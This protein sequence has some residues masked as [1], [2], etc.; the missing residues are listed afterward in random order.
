MKKEGD[1]FTTLYNND[2]IV[3]VVMLWLM[4]LLT[5]IGVGALISSSNDYLTTNSHRQGKAAFFAADSGLA[6]GTK[7]LD[8]L[9]A[10][11][12]VPTSAQLAALAAPS[13]SGFTFDAFSV[14]AAGSASLQTITT[15]PY[16]GLRASST[17]YTITSQ[18]SRT[19]ADSGTVR[20]V[21]SLQDQVIPLFQFGVFYNT[22]LEI[23][24]GA[25]MTFNGRIHSN[26]DLYL[27]NAA[28][29]NSR[30]TSAGAIFNCRKD[31]P[32]TCNGAQ[33]QKPG[34]TYAGL[35]YGHNDSNWVNR[36]SSDW[37][38]LVQDSAHG[39]QALNLPIGSSN[40]V[41]LI[42]RGDV[43][44]PASSSESSSLKSSRMYWQADLRI[45]DGIAYDKNGNTVTL[46]PGVSTVKTMYD[47]REGKTITVRE[48]DIGNLNTCTCRPA[49]GILYISDTQNAGNSKAVRL[50][51]GATLPSG[52]LTVA[53]NNPIYV[54]GNYNTVNKKGAAIL[55]D[56]VTML[57]GNWKDTT[58]A[59]PYTAT[60]SLSTRVPTSTTVNSAIV[61]GNTPTSVGSYNGG[62]ENLP[63]FLENWSGIDFT[64]AGSLI[65]LWQTQQ[66][67]SNW[68]GTGSV[69]NAPN[70]I[71]SYDTAFDTPANLP[72]GTPRV[73]TL[74]RVQWT[75]M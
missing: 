35:T 60:T 10:G 15:G 71:W 5:M 22:D 58:D 52:G 44:N 36:S 72:P 53:S 7:S 23:F 70:R 59:S 16:A 57:S 11:T 63:R 3:I 6:F 2:G 38:G 49:N 51:D 66:V 24:P 26:K 41:D 62:L 25:S 14:T 37:G 17:P 32:S 74:T 18:A 54:K 20:L 43:V 56:A 30:L 45:L 12:L 73:R 65:N 34:G 67:S 64:Y 9:L 47:Y 68:P 50:S 39:V 4:V 48:I 13:I 27:G 61:T 21:E 28:T 8:N 42:N 40:P 55:G 33:I 29:I 75:R 19:V 46:D 31:D 69:Y 1:R